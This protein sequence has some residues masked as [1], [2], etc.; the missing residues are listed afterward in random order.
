MSVL[1]R[2][3]EAPVP[4]LPAW[5]A[6]INKHTGKL[7]TPDRANSLRSILDVCHSYNLSPVVG[8]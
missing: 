3:G 2:M 7:F 6:A 5:E 8:G 4:D 1:A